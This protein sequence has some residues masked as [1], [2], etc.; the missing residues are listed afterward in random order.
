MAGDKN[1]GETRT[2]SEVTVKDRAAGFA[3]A[4]NGLAFFCGLYMSVVGCVLIYEAANGHLEFTGDKLGDW[5]TIIYSTIM[6]ML[7]LA[8]TMRLKFILRSFA[9]AS[10]LFGKGLLCLFVGTTMICTRCHVA[11]HLTESVPKPFFC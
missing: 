9:F 3:A 6:G 5:I 1:E 4:V 10:H 11:V 7:V 8:S 2:G